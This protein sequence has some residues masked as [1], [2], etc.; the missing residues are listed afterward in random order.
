MCLEPTLIDNR[1]LNPVEKIACVFVYSFC[2]EL[3]TGSDSWRLVIYRLRDFQSKL[4]FCTDILRGVVYC[5][6]LS[7]FFLN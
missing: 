5:E 2:P 1:A 7:F 6:S 3:V 4:G